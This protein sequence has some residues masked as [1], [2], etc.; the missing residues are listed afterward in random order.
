MPRFDL[1]VRAPSAA[2][3][4][5]A[6]SSFYWTATGSSTFTPGLGPN[7][8]RL[9]PVRDLNVDL[10]RIAVGIYAA[11]RSVLRTGGGSNWNQREIE[12]QIPVSDATIW[13]AEG[14]ELASLVGFLT[15]DKWSF[16]FTSEATDPEPVALKPTQATRV[17]LLS[18]GADSAAGALL[19]R[20][21]LDPSEH[22]I[23]VSHFSNNV[24]A[25]VQRQVAAMA[26]TLVPGASQR[27]L[28][29]H[30]NRTRP[31]DGKSFPSEASSRSRS[32]LFLALGLAAASIDGVPLWIPENGF[33]S[34]N[35]PLGPE[36]L[37]SLSTRTTHPAFIAGL[38]SVLT[39]VGAQSEI[40]NP[41]LRSTKGE[42]F[43]DV[44]AALGPD[45]ASDYLSST[46]SCAHTGQR[47]HGVSP[48]IAC[49]VCFGCVMRRSSFLAAGIEDRSSYADASTSTQ[50]GHWLAAQSIEGVVR[51]FA[52]R[53]VRTRDLLAM[54]LPPE[55]SLA[56]ATDLCSRGCAELLRYS[57]Q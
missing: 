28:P 21:T 55:Y 17:V 27:H 34:I 22:Q 11:D 50:L 29:L 38:S 4:P 30:L 10:S 20:R 56:D 40:V 57:T 2:S 13:Q 41:F 39:R 18:G 45:A 12:L 15:G 32:L 46:N 47:A 9:G 16:T 33:A 8:G 1:H 26:E 5:D 42:M 53:G 36:R 35:P 25:P 31:I 48:A 52:H 6:A 44:A 14:S 54:S 49:G 19:S 24:I 3:T 7:L 37:G 23:L 51:N 43:A